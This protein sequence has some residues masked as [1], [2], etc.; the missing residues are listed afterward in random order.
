MKIYHAN[1][2]FRDERS[3]VLVT[4]ENSSKP[5]EHHEQHSPDG[6]SWGYEGSGPS[7]LAKDILWDLLEKKPSNDL[8][9]TFKR[10]FVA[11]WPQDE[12]WMITEDQIR[13]S[14]HEEV[15]DGA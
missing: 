15:N 11:L 7:E 5:L 12:G 13:Q 1:C 10:D 4:D 14:F 3:L 8:Y 2:G 9:Q 6:H